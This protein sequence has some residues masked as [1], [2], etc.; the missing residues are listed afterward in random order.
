MYVRAYFDYDILLNA[1]SDKHFKQ[2]ILKFNMTTKLKMAAIIRFIW[3]IT[4][5]V[6]ILKYTP[7]CRIRPK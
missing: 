7:E 3:P 5:D 4:Y 6:V 1:G 2:G